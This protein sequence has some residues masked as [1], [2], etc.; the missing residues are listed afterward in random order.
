M[1]TCIACGKRVML[2]VSFRKVSFC[3]FCSL[4]VHLPLWQN[5]LFADLSQL[6]KQRDDVYRL[7]VNNNFSKAAVDELLAYFSEEEGAGFL[8]AIDGCKGQTIRIYKKY[9]VIDTDKESFNID[10]VSKEYFKAIQSTQTHMTFFD[11]PQNQRVL[12]NGLLS[13]N[14]I[15]T[16]IGLARS[17]AIDA[18]QKE[19]FS[20][21]EKVIVS[22][23]E[24]RVFFKDIKD[25]EFCDC[26]NETIG[27]IKFEEKNSDILF[28]FRGNSDFDNSRLSKKVNKLYSLIQ[29]QYARVMNTPADMED[30]KKEN[31]IFEM[32]RQYKSLLDDQII[33]QEEFDRK[34][35]E[36]LHL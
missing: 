5:K 30:T 23:G 11:N 28:F 35:R 13:G 2:P 18:A 20:G 7:A 34:K 24:K 4:K 21:K 36:L 3:K 32:I 26:K 15:H 9:V 33:S 12:L 14:I 29:E 16:G 19:F 10:E 17:A 22:Y 8:G 27:F 25:I 6:Q 1:E 31:D